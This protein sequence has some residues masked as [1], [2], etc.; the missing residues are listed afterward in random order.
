[1][2]IREFKSEIWLRVPPEKGF[3][4]FA[5]ACNLETITPPWLSFKVI[6][7]RPIAM[8]EGT[9][10]DYKLHIHGLPVRWRTRIS[11]WQPS[12]CFV[13]EQ[14]RG[15]YRQWIHEHTFEEQD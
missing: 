14:L 10:I 5:D 1:M 3:P 8:H 4:F 11:K 9:L 2:C 12:Y 15:P 7:P 13:D 6:T